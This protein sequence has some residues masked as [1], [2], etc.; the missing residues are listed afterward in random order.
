[1]REPRDS[2]SIDAAPQFVLILRPRRS[3]CCELVARPRPEVNTLSA[4]RRG[5]LSRGFSHDRVLI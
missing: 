1:L 4:R 3:V 5:H 2:A